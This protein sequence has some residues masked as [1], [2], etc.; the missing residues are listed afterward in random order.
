MS[1]DS[2]VT[3][4][5]ISAL[6]ALTALA[7]SLWTF[8]KSQK[9]RWDKERLDVLTEVRISVKR[10]QG[11]AG[12]HHKDVDKEIEFELDRSYYALEKLLILFPDLT[13]QITELQKLIVERV[14]FGKSCKG[15]ENGYLLY[16]DKENPTYKEIVSLEEEIM[17]YA[18]DHLKID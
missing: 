5:I 4:N 10:V 15:Q 8:R 7:F 6:V 17:A 14:K 16:Q 9:T 3:G 2:G 13:E 18:R 1:G 11:L 12:V